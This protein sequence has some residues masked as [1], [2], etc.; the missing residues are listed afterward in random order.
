VGIPVTS[1]EDLPVPSE[2][3]P[4]PLQAA[5]EEETTE[6]KAEGTSPD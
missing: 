6:E 3:L 1:V 5:L 2:L 4:P